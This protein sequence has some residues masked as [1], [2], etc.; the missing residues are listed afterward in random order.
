MIYHWADPE[1]RILQ[2]FGGLRWNLSDQPHHGSANPSLEL[3]IVDR[4]NTANDALAR[5]VSDL[6]AKIQ[7]INLRVKAIGVAAAFF[8][9]SGGAIATYR[10]NQAKTEIAQLNTSLGDAKTGLKDVG[11]SIS[12]LDGQVDDLERQRETI[13]AIISQQLKQAQV[14]IDA[15]TAAPSVSSLRRRCLI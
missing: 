2:S 14:R 10:L 3:R 15:A 9:L 7:R 11:D 12:K 5:R 13:G 6:E 4:I 1:R 8:G